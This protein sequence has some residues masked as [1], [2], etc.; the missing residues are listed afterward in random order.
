MIRGA[1]SDMM[2]YRDALVA[3]GFSQKQADAMT[4]TEYMV[5]Q[6]ALSALG[7]AISGGVMGGGAAAL[8]NTAGRGL[9]YLDTTAA[10]QSAMTADAAIDSSYAQMQENGLFGQ[11]EAQRQRTRSA[12]DEANYRNALTMRGGEDT[13]TQQQAQAIEKIISG[14]QVSEEE[15]RSIS[16]SNMAT[17]VL[18]RMMDERTA[19]NREQQ[20]VSAPQQT[21]ENARPAATVRQRQVLDASSVFGENGQKAAQAS[22]DG[23]ISA[24]R[25]LSGFAE[26]YEAGLSG[27]SMEQAQGRY[28]RALTQEQR[29]AA[30]D[31]GR[32]DAAMNL[33]NEQARA[34]YASVAGEDSGLVLDDYVQQNL[35]NDTV[36]RLNEVSKALGVRVQFVDSVAGGSANAAITGSTIQVEKDN[37]NPVNFLLG[38]EWTHRM[39]E[40]APEQYRAFRSAIADEI[41]YDA[42]VKLER[43]RSAGVDADLDYALDEAAADYAGK[44]MEDGK[45]MDEFISRHGS[46]RNLLQKMLD[47]IRTIIRKL[48]G[49][50]KNVLNDEEKQH[51]L[52]AK[53]KLMRALEAARK[54]AQENSR[55]NEN[56]AREGGEARLSI[57][58][59]RYNNPYVVIEEDILAGVPR[60]EWVKTVKDNLR[61]KFPDGVTVGNNVIEIDKQSREEMTYSRYTRHLMRTEPELYADKLRATNNA[62]EILRASRNY[63][64]EALAHIR[65]DNIQEFARGEVLMEIGGNGYSAQVVVAMRSNGRL[66]LYDILQMEPATI[67]AKNKKSN[68]AIAKDPS[69]R[70]D[71]STASGFTNSISETGGDVNGRFSLKD[72]DSQGRELTP[73]QQE[74]FQDSKILDEDGQLLVVYHGTDEEFTVFDRSKGRTSMDIQGM[75]FSPWEDDAIGYGGNVGAYYLNIKNPADEST[76]Y[77]A[78]R[79]FQGQN[80]TGIKAREY[81]ISLGYDGVNNGGEEYIAF[82]P[83]QIK[84]V[85]NL[86]PTSD[87]DIRYSLKAGDN[88]RT[89]EQQEFFKDSKARVNECGNYGVLDGRPLVSSSITQSGMMK[90]RYLTG[91]DWEKTPRGMQQMIFLQPRPISASGSIRRIFPDRPVI[92]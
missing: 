5:N 74:Y 1:N 84:R 81:L 7:G 52:E 35:D 20:T 69:P 24:D 36:R 13:I 67:Q 34:Q 39:Q 19:S 57:K 9:D 23:S 60:S 55:G 66:L 53:E 44:L 22:Y 65:R 32:Q 86:N 92:V 28:G 41:Q 76:G 21:R 80:E 3:A 71:R 33:R 78:L 64:N 72:M 91:K 68:A 37:R 83:E 30:Y 27:L 48:T 62:D 25:Y 45:L 70:T 61:Q 15:E 6:P 11:S 49:K 29:M 2:Q 26:Y 79:K 4:M 89:A 56:T 43:Y 40:L 82:Y 10:R 75:F 85:D 73:E 77:S 42:R 17:E 47:A 12:I 54:Q 87:P 16:E 38:H 58:Y 50:E 14:E 63:V 18:T 8:G 46:D 31:S 59:D 51:L 88:S 90:S